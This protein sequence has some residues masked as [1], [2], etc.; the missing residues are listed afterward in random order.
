MSYYERQQYD[1]LRVLLEANR[2]GLIG[3]PLA[4]KVILFVVKDT[5]GITLEIEHG[6]DIEIA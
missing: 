1:L 3:S 5:D 2:E 4:I 6:M